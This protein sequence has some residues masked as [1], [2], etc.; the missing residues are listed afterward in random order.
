MFLCD[1]LTQQARVNALRDSRTL[2]PSTI[3]LIAAAKVDA[4]AAAAVAAE[5]AAVAAVVST[6]ARERSSGGENTHRDCGVRKADTETA[7]KTAA[8]RGRTDM[9]SSLGVA[10]GRK[11]SSARSFQGDELKSGREEVG[12]GL[13][14]ATGSEPSR[15]KAAEGEAA[16]AAAVAAAAAAT[17]A[18]AVATVQAAELAKNQDPLWEYRAKVN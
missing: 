2:T 8:R 4:A 18:A 3:D 15:T 12:L 10:A 5:A 14:I 1:G 9:I 16:Q 6:S 17:A 11:S 13:R 7:A